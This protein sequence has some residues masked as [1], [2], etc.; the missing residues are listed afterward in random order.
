MSETDGLATWFGTAAVTGFGLVTPVGLSAPASI[1]ALRSGVSRIE[2]IPWY[3]IE[4]A[5]GEA[6][7]ITG[8]AVPILTENRQGPERI[9]R[10]IQAALAETLSSA[11]IPNPSRC[12]V[13]LGLAAPGFGGRILDPI[14]PIRNGIGNRLP[15][16]L[17]S[18]EVRLVAAGRA[19]AL[20]ALRE[21]LGALTRGEADIALAG[22]ADSLLSP[23]TL[24][25]LEENGRLRTGRRS[26]GILPGEAAGFLAL[27]M[28]SSA[29]RRKAEIRSL[30]VGAAGA[31]DSTPFG[32]P[33][34]A[35]TLSRV[36][37]SLQSVLPP[38][39]PLFV[40]DSN[41][42]RQ[43]ATEWMMANSRGLGPYS[44][45]TRRWMPA[46]YI[47]DSGAG[48]G[49]VSLAWAADA[50]SKGYAREGRALVYGSSDEGAREAAV[51][52]PA[53]EVS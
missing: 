39:T 22:G 18:A 12:R 45:P 32:E 13:Y 53:E 27:E 4:D 3:E 15:A 36:F 28:L 23:L 44:E 7:P 24:S 41:G 30:I 50:L 11:R 31:Q 16:E 6:I 40:S 10:L 46:E 26:T 29:K 8:G 20:T 49:A 14:E 52:L 47:G 43:W 25:W 1:A 2:E 33:T 37:R 42:E 21:A 5:N 51:L 35:E 34:R 9:V 48:A 17:K 19:A 38:P